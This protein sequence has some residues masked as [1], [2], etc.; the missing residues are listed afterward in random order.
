[1]RLLWV[2]VA[3]CPALYVTQEMVARLGAVTGSAHARLT[4]ERFGRLW[5]AFSL[6]D[7]LVLNVATL[8]TE[9]I[10]VALALS[11][12]GGGRYVSVPG[13]AAYP[14]YVAVF[15]AGILGQNY[16]VQGMTW[17]TARGRWL[18]RRGPA[19]TAWALDRRRGCC[20]RRGGRSAAASPNWNLRAHKQ[21]DGLAP[22]RVFIRGRRP[23]GAGR[24]PQRHLNP[25]IRRPPRG[26]NAR[27]RSQHCRGREP[28]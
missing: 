4:L 9:F 18:E 7:L 24:R 12:L 17:T 22:R 15:S 27:S 14:A 26:A 1:M 8:V 23:N 6:A 28:Q 13:G 19:Q 25:W 11:Y 16:D 3:L 5:C 10:G 21:N 2:L 20:N